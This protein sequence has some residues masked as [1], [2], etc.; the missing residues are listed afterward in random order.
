MQ[1]ALLNG[2]TNSRIN[3]LMTKN[4]KRT[5]W[6]Y[7]CLA[8]VNQP[9]PVSQPTFKFKRFGVHFQVQSFCRSFFFSVADFFSRTKSFIDIDDKSQSTLSHLV[10]VEA[11]PVIRISR[12]LESVCLCPKAIPLSGFHCT[13]KQS[14]KTQASISALI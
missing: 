14:C 3:R 4:L 7:P 11:D 8:W 12:L 5:R 1:W 6:G 2:I 13:C 9:A 10:N